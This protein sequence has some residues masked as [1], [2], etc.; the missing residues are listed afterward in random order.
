MEGERPRDPLRCKPLRTTIATQTAVLDS[1]TAFLLCFSR[2]VINIEHALRSIALFLV[3]EQ[4][5]TQRTF[6]IH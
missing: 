1:V 3:R 6:K 5:P 4:L 2:L